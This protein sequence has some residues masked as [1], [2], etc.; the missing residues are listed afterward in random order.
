M[1][2]VTAHGLLEV[3][4]APCVHAVQTPDVLQTPVTEPEVHV[5]PAG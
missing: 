3:Q 2:A 1:V 5:V 4:V